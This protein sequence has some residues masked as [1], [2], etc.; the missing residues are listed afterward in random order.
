MSERPAR[1]DDAVRPQSG[2]VGLS[3]VAIAVQAADP[4]ADLLVAALGARRGEEELLDQG[5]LRVVFVHLGPVTLELLEP[6][7]GEHTVARFVATRGQGLHHVS[8]DVRDLVG[9]LAQAKAA[10]IRLIDETPRQGA[11]G[12]KVAFL[13]PSSLGGVLVEL[14][15]TPPAGSPAEPGQ[16]SR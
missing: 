7:G 4:L 12:T 13:H 14:C 8:F 11:G 1:P 16:E 2:V 15:E 5:A 9:H 6:R 10:G 3:H